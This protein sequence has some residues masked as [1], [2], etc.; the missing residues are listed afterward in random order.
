M[1]HKRR[2]RSPRVSGACRPDRAREVARQAGGQDIESLR[3]DHRQLAHDEEAPSVA[4]V[5]D[6]LGEG[7]VVSLGARPHG[8]ILSPLTTAPSSVFELC[9]LHRPAHGRCD[10]VADLREGVAWLES[11]LALPAATAPS[12]AR[13]KGLTGLAGLLYWQGNAD[14][15][16][17]I[18]EEAL[19]IY[20]ELGDER[21]P[22]R[23]TTSRRD[24]RGPT[25]RSKSIAGSATTTTRCWSMPGSCSKR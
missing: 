12:S 2:A 11:L 17:T 6:R 13:A 21:R 14:R 10:E 15:A 22:R 24:R 3:P 19:A 8:G 18:Y 7:A 4:K 16:L 5:L 9:G 25:K 23:D 20:R 1:D